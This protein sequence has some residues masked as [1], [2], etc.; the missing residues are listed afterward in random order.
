MLRDNKEKQAEIK[1]KIIGPWEKNVKPKLQKLADTTFFLPVTI[2]K[3]LWKGNLQAKLIA[4]GILGS[5]V[6]TS[7][8]V[9]KFSHQAKERLVEMGYIKEVQK[10]K[11][12][13]KSDGPMKSF[14]EFV[15]RHRSQFD[16]TNKITIGPMTLMATS[17]H[18]PEITAVDFR[19]TI[20][21]DGKRSSLF[22]KKRE[23]QAQDAII[24]AVEP[25]KVDH[26]KT[27]KGKI[28][29]RKICIDALHRLG[30]PNSVKDV[31]FADFF[32]N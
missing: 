13:K 3:M 25:F 17:E 31:Y 15:H 5:I 20:V 14:G 26:F 22:Y 8:A 6:L 4:I 10:V 27:K 7:A 24:S 11:R 16:L 30:R 1:E 18:N 12:K 19:V 29:L 2:G 21:T 9:I 32:G 23:E 28:E